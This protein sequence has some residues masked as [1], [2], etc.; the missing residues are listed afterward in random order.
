[1]LL[2]K[3]IV[4]NFQGIC[5]KQEIDFGVS[6][7][8]K[9]ILKNNLMFKEEGNSLIPLVSGF[10]GKNASGKTSIIEAFKFTIDR[11][12]N[13][14]ILFNEFYRHYIFHEK[15]NF[16][17]EDN[18]IINNFLNL[19]FQNKRKLFPN[20][21]KAFLEQTF[22][23]FSHDLENP[24]EIQAFFKE[25]KDIY[26]IKLNF[27]KININLLTYKNNKKIKKFPKISYFQLE[28]Y[29][30]ESKYRIYNLENKKILKL[31]Y[32]LI[33][34]IGY[35]K[36]NLILRM[37]DNNVKQID[38]QI[39]NAKETIFNNVCMKNKTIISFYKLS[40]GTI[41]ILK[42]IAILIIKSFNQKDVL[43]IFLV[44]EINNYLHAKLVHFL[45]SLLSNNLSNCQII[46]TSHSPSVM[47][48][49]NR[50]AIWVIQ[51]ED[52]LKVKKVASILRED[53][54]FY[55]KFIREEISSHP[56]SSEINEVLYELSKK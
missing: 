54:S 31:Q 34:L 1:M 41:K 36:Y 22:N 30:F 47:E 5:E 18:K 15:K 21:Y 33:K 26:E 43:T 14:E 4:K 48:S 46:F 45:F 9:E 24:I 16:I 49:L 17:N 50:H 35:K 19:T 3:L 52:H 55:K 8:T 44:D 39:N 28:F 51:N 42:F 40:T 37:I 10:I 32:K 23:N 11:V 12:L 56:S 25:K 38:R 7:K 13:L 2:Q 6:N 27:S 29:D 53:N 20:E